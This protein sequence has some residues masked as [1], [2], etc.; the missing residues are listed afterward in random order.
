MNLK[1]QNK[2]ILVITSINK[3]NQAIKNFEK[4]CKK[5]NTDLKFN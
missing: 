2:K 5:N 3:P 1:K 4:L